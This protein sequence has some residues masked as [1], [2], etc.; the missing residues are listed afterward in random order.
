MDRHHEEW[1]LNLHG[2]GITGAQVVLKWEDV[3]AVEDEYVGKLTEALHMFLVSLRS[4]SFHFRSF[5]YFLPLSL[6]SYHIW[7]SNLLTP[8]QDF[9][10]IPTQHTAPE[11]ST[12]SPY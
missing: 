8:P 6:S 9:A 1:S 11:I 10:L 4:M 7:V 3:A 5:P 12:Q 2:R